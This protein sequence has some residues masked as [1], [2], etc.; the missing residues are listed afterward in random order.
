VKVILKQFQPPSL[1]LCP[2]RLY[3]AGVLLP[4][5]FTRP[6]GVGA[7]MPFCVASWICGSKYP[8]LALNGPEHGDNPDQ[9]IQ[10]GKMILPG[11]NGIEIPLMNVP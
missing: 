10:G 4:I 5:S 8:G 9:A 1:P 7:D 2:P 11:S 3:S 6:C